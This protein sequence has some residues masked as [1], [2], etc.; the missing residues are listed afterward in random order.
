MTNRPLARDIASITFLVLCIG[1]LM[2]VNFWILHPFL[3][4]LDW[5]SPSLWWRPGRSCSI[6]SD[7]W[8]TNAPSRLH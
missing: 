4:G 7:G 5:V 6:S 1:E 2:A 8:G 3:A